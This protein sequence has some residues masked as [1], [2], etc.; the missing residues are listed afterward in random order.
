MMALKEP[1]LKNDLKSALDSIKSIAPGLSI[2]LGGH[3]AV[4]ATARKLKS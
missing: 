1:S 3:D 4:R 2:V